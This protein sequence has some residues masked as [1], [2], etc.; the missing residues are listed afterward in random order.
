MMA[1][2][3]CTMPIAVSR[4]SVRNKRRAG[5]HRHKQRSRKRR[6]WGAASY[7]EHQTEC[8]YYVEGGRGTTYSS[9]TSYSIPGQ[10]LHGSRTTGTYT[11]ID[12]T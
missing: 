10:E 4:Q 6:A 11:R 3:D 9:T 2:W 1:G 8:F 12:D 7:A 5:S